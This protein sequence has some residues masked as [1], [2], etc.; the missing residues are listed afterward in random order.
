MK[1]LEIFD[2]DGK[3]LHIADVIARFLEQEAQKVKFSI[4]DVTVGIDEHWKT[5]EARLV[6]YDFDYRILN[7]Y[8]LNGL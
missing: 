6:V 7:E 3:A 8:P 5:K 4:D 1:D 2:K